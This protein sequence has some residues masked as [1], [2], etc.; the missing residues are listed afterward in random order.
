M[1][2]RETAVAFGD[3]RGF[4]SYTAARG[5][6][7]A[8]RVAEAFADF[9]RAEL[10]PYDGRL[11]KTFGD[12]VMV[13]FPSAEGA[14]R[15]ATGTQRALS[16]YNEAHEDEPMS[17][18]FGV[19]WGSV[20]ETQGDLFGHSVNMAKRLAD[21]AKG[22][23]IIVAPDVREATQECSDLVY[24]DLGL[25][26][27]KGLGSA[28]LYELV[29]RDEAAK[30]SLSDSSLDVVLTGDRKLIFEFAKPMAET[31]ETMKQ[32]LAALDQRGA[33]GAALRQKLS[34]RLEREMP[35]WIEAVRRFGGSALEHGLDDI[36]ATVADGKL[37]IELPGGRSF[38]FT[39]RQIGR[40]EAEQFLEKLAALRRSGRR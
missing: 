17:A 8:L 39:E 7:A 26:R 2:E 28:R 13:A 20:L 40:E 34:E 23:Q 10:P 5:D 6:R 29:W 25:Q 21:V 31:I 35:R 4:T 11:V 15:A 22:C 18:G 27:L 14:V 37:T 9:V 12:G 30:L 19:T 36:A 24:R 1:D 32:K 38:S 16:H 3:L 33:P